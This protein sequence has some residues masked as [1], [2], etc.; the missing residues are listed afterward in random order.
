MRHVDDTS[1]AVSSHYVSVRI[2]INTYLY[3]QLL[4]YTM[5][6]ITLRRCV[7][8]KGAYIRPREGKL[9][10]TYGHD[11]RHELAENANANIMHMDPQVHD[12]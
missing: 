2:E 3:L 5:R 6:K 11:D 1:T 9:E 12:R 8:L 10:L 4:P 7:P